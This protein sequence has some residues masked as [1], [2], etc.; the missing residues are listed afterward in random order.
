[1]L[2]PLANAVE[3]GI[4]VCQGARVEFALDHFPLRVFLLTLKFNRPCQAA[5]RQPGFRKVR[6]WSV[7]A[8]FAAR[9]EIRR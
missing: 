9:F 8:G 3:R 5:M 6:R 1:M 7:T 4:H 2:N